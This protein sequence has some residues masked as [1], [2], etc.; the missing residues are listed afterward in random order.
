MKLSFRVALAA[1]VLMSAFGA[2]PASAQTV[3][4]GSLAGK[5]ADQQGGVLPGA[6]VHA[7]HTPT[8]TTYQ[9]VTD[10]DGRYVI[11]NVRVGWPLQDHRH[12]VRLQGRDPG[13]RGR[14]AG[15]R[16]RPRISR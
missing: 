15:R 12:D 9:A 10:V 13:R 11:L 4:T 6:T 14:D 1:A 16:D 3:T 7:V 8:G 2:T 5:V